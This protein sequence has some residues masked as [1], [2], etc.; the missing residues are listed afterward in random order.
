MAP[1]PLAMS[2]D[3]LRDSASGLDK[4]ADWL[5]FDRAGENLSGAASGMSGFAT[6]S[7]CTE[8][9]GSLTGQARSLGNDVSDFSDK[10]YLAAQ[11]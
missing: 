1:E 4:I 11:R 3:A 2:I 10:L 9:G 5:W 7:A 6:A 8:V